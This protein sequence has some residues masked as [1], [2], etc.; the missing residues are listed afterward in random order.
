M[1]SAL[2]DQREI[3]SALKQV[4]AELADQR[5]SDIDPGVVILRM[6]N[7]QA[8]YVAS[9]VITLDRELRRTAKGME[10]N[11]LSLESSIAAQFNTPAGSDARSSRRNLHPLVPARASLNVTA[12]EQGSSV[13]LLEPAGY[14]INLLTSTPLTVFLNTLALYGCSKT[15]AIWVRAKGWPG[16]GKRAGRSDL[17]AVQEAGG[18]GPGAILEAQPVGVQFP[19]QAGQMDADGVS[20]SGPAEISYVRRHADGTSTVMNVKLGG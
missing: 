12:A 18:A 3:L 20:I 6:D 2:V 19:A 13:L 1:G 14:A 11:N 15:V 7:P 5:I 8:Y 17:H 4:E 9:T 16:K 10:F